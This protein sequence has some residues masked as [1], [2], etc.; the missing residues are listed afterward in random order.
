MTSLPPFLR[1]QNVDTELHRLGRANEVDRRR[2][3]ASGHFHHLLHCV[4]RGV[5]DGR[6]GTHLAGLRALL[7]IDVGNDHLARHHSRRDMHGAAADA[8]GTD[9]HQVVVA[10][11]M[12]AGSF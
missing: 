3:A 5:V 2:G 7:R 1:I 9:D 10:A 12:P 4:G 11:Q 8:T 6:D